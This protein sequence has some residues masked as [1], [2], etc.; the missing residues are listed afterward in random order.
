[1]HQITHLNSGAAK[2]QLKTLQLISVIA[3]AFGE[4]HAL[5]G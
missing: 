3:Q 2:C 4:K 1:M 5:W